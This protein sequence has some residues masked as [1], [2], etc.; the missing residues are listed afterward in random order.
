MRSIQGE[1]V[2]PNEASG[3]SG[4]HFGAR[5][6]SRGSSIWTFTQSGFHSVVAYDPSRDDAGL[7]LPEST[8]PKDLLLVRARA[9]EDLRN[10]LEGLELPPSRAAATPRADYPWRAALSRDEWSR[11]LATETDRLDY[12]NFKSRVQ[13]LSG[14]HRHDVY[15]RVWSVM[16]GIRGP[17][18]NSR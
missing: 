16:R 7:E 3:S 1:G 4:H 13:R 9:E 11:F 6:R 12:P 18:A 2:G 17:V 15:L 10:L 14:S 8:Q 5:T